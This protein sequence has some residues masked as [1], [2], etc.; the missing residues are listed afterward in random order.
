MTTVSLSNAK[1]AG[2]KVDALIVGVTKGPRGVSL[3]PGAEDVDKAF[4]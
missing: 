2:L 4:K 1:A 3:G